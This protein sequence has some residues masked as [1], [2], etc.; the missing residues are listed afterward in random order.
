LI[1]ALAVNSGTL[2]HPA[3][4]FAFTNDAAYVPIRDV[5]ASAAVSFLHAS[6]GV[7][8]PVFDFDPMPL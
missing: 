6:E 1:P 7:M 5:T 4:A 8:L 2:G 3:S